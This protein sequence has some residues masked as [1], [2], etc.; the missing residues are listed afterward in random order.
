MCALLPAL[1]TAQEQPYVSRYDFYAGYS[2]FNSPKVALIEHGFQ[3]QAAIR[4]K[5]WYSLGFDYSR[6]SG[7]LKLTPDLLPTALQQQL[8]AQ[9]GAIAAAGHLPA[10]YTLA[11]TTAS[12]TQ[13]FA[14]GPQLSYRHFRAVTLFVRP[15]LGAIREVA[16]PKPED[17][18]AKAIVASLAPE[19]V[20][21]DWQ[22]F[23]GVGGGFDLNASK[24]VSLRVQ[25]DFV[26]DHL[27][28]DILRDGRR[29]VRF[30]IGP[31]FNIGRNVQ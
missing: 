21:H 16:T 31:A 8:G 15:S 7:D 20:K 29:T 14:A 28:N 9:L 12:E 17:A 18:I 5:R 6:V 22:G 13:T 24:H 30:S 25:A 27:F 4:P 3:F 23:Y 11:V 2:Y 10:G 26:Y 1:S 19:G